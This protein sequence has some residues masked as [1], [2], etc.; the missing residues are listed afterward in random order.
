MKIFLIL[1]VLYFQ[2][3]LEEKKIGEVFGSKIID[4]VIFL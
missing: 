3:E 2:F 1:M 4:Y